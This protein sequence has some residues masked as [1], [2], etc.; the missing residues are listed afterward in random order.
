MLGY[1]LTQIC[2]SRFIFLPFFNNFNEYFVI[3]FHPDDDNNTV[4]GDKIKNE[5]SD[6]Q[7]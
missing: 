7:S 6:V 2:G 5:V 3:S 1:G 4:N